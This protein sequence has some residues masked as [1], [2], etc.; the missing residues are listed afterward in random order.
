MKT[1]K[2]PD[3]DFVDLPSEDDL[4]WDLEASEDEYKVCGSF[5][6]EIDTGS[7]SWKLQRKILIFFILKFLPRLILFIL[8]L[9]VKPFFCDHSSMSFLLSSISR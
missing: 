6:K 1:K 5:C 4:D 3:G 9:W 2:A 7:P 8:T